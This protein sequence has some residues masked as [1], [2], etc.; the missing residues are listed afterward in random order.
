MSWLPIT[1]FPS[2]FLFNKRSPTALHV[3]YYVLPRIF[4]RKVVS[5]KERIRHYWRKEKKTQICL[6]GDDYHRLACD[7]FQSGTSLM[8]FRRNVMPLFSRSKR[9]AIRQKKKKKKQHVA[10]CYFTN[11][12]PLRIEAKSSQMSTGYQI[13]RGYIQRRNIIQSLPW[14]SLISNSCVVNFV[15]S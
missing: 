9:N 1:V 14:Q 4:C 11:S 13:A 7:A 5:N 3:V 12:A 2:Y 6:A 15:M 10:C 8:K